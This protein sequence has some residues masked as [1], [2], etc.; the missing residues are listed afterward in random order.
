MATVPAELCKQT[1]GRLVDEAWSIV[2]ASFKMYKPMIRDLTLWS[3][4]LK[5]MHEA[6]FT[7]GGKKSTKGDGFVGDH[8]TN[9]SISLCSDASVSEWAPSNWQTSNVSDYG[10]SYLG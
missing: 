2:E 5:P 3:S 7:R 1:E 6:R 8:A 9:T 4:V 10:D